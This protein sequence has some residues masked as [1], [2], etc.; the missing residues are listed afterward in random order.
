MVDL[1]TKAR[2]N[3]IAIGECGLD[4]SGKNSTKM[5]DQRKA[6]LLQIALAKKLRKP[7]VLHIRDAEEEA[8]GLLEE[9]ELPKDWP[10]HRYC[11]LFI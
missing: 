10:I 4:R 3:F 7:L 1:I 2:S 5:A 8:I 9:S 11:S 6:F